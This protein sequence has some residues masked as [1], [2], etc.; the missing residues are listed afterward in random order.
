MNGVCIVSASGQN[1][2]F[3]EMLAAVESALAANG[4]TTDRAEDHF[5]PPREGV[6]YLFIP[7]E[8]VPL[9]EQAGQPSPAHLARS[10]ALCTEQPG[11]HWFEETA[12]IAAR[13]A[14]AVD[15]NQEG[16]RELRRRGVEAEFLQLGYVPDW[17]RWGGDESRARPIDVTF[18]GGYTQRRAE[19]LARCGPVLAE[20][21][22]SLHLFE[23]ALPHRADSRSFLSG[24]RKWE[25]L[26]SARTIVNVHRSELG[27]CEWQRFVGAM[28]NG[29][30]VLSEHSLG[31]APFVAG[32]HFA[33]FYRESLPHVLRALLDDEQRLAEM[34]QSAYRLL[35]DELPMTRTVVVLAEA[36]VRAA[37]APLNRAELRQSRPAP[38]AAP[39]PAPEYVRLAQH[40]GEL[41]R[42][43]MALKQLY[44]GQRDLHRRIADLQDG[45]A[46]DRVERLGR[47]TGGE[48]RVSVLLTSYNYKDVVAQAIR[49]VALS[50]FRDHELVVVDDASTDGSAAVIE[51]EVSRYPWLPVHLIAR[52]RNRG[53]AAA[54]NLAARQARGEYV[55]ILDADNFIY[56]HAL[57]RLVDALDRDPGAA[58]AYGI[59]EV[60]T[61]QGAS[62]LKS[63]LDWDPERLRYGNFVDAM[64]MIRRSA[65]E[66]AG[67]YSSDPRL[68]GWEDFALWCAL[69]E[70]G[71]RGVLVPEI[72]AAYRS[73]IGSMIALTDIDASA[74][75]SAL[76]DRHAIL[77]G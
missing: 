26:A 42:A 1:V 13:S 60:F 7:H 32:E 15:V 10:V 54:R 55:F 35:K 46:E 59:L 71:Q 62:D 39:A 65:L 16:V 28:S 40:R 24:E 3:E 64:S 52:G 5:P 48:P 12:A 43:L 36:L 47:H 34:R 45:Q 68:Y 37:A 33:S 25:H 4:V 53:L 57:G 21:R 76:L 77:H 73:S 70:R 18:M 67:G 38:S 75:W 58:F 69:A 8:Y 31:A 14:H 2:F 23:S 51:A 72:L 29:C 63:W 41:D 11:T 56:P 30:V 17:D 27:Y 22:A 6:A 9:V 50:G 61:S 44:L 19:A 66:E 49:S 20:R 74:A